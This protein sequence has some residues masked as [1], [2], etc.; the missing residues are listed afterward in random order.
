MF[1]IRLINSL[2][3]YLLIVQGIVLATVR[4]KQSL[5]CME[6]HS[7]GGRWGR[8]RN[9]HTQCDVSE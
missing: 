6:L 3:K 5:H 4:V 7:N 1:P 9:I 8:G 2:H